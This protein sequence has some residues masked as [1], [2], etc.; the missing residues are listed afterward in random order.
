MNLLKSKVLLYALTLLSLMS[1]LNFLYVE[2]MKSV[3]F[4]IVVGYLTTFFSKNMIVVLATA[5]VSTNLLMSRSVYEGMKEG[6]SFS[7][8]AR[9]VHELGAGEITAV[10]DKEGTYSVT[11]DDEETEDAEGVPSNELSAEGDGEAEEGGGEEEA[12]EGG[13]EEG[14]EEEG[15][16]EG[17]EEETFTTRE[18]LI[19]RGATLKQNLKHLEGMI[20]K[21]GM[22]GLAKETKELM[23]TQK[24][25]MS[26]L[27]GMAPLMGQMGGMMKQLDKVG[28]S[29][30]GLNLPG[31]SAGKK[32]KN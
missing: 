12:E 14:A 26:A 6:H 5:I 3:T 32:K 4:F 1:L 2:D 31:F 25:M 18:N 8:G 19:D 13:E 10:D 15:E 21:G 16:G 17:E 24:T 23:A 30:E 7:V 9:V 27:E 28:G 22:K 11:F 20:G 29:L